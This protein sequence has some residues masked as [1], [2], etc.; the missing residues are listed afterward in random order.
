MC[1]PSPTKLLQFLFLHYLLLQLPTST[2]TSTASSYPFQHPAKPVVYL[3]K[4]GANTGATIDILKQA[5]DSTDIPYIQ[6][7][8]SP[9]STNIPPP[10]HI[11][12][13]RPSTPPNFTPSPSSPSPPSLQK[14]KK[15]ECLHLSVP[16]PSQV[17]KQ[18]QD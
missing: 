14:K 16:L 18:H 8:P 6:D 10:V 1:C 9:P 13:P 17:A 2:S 7:P 5:V 15:K 12:P 3:Y 11:T 4:A